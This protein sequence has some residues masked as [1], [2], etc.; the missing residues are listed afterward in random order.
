[1]WTQPCGRKKHGGVSAREL[2]FDSKL[3]G[4]RTS[5]LVPVALG[6][7]AP[8]LAAEVDV[9]LRV[10][11]AADRARVLLG[12]PVANAKAAEDMSA[13]RLVV[14]GLVVV[15][16]HRAHGH[17]QADAAGHGFGHLLLDV[18]QTRRHIAVGGEAAHDPVFRV[19]ILWQ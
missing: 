11:A 12:E 1:M 13:G 14:G 10:L 9:R 6:L 5:L 8:D 3:A 2:A 7:R 18:E 4:P 16:Q 15:E 19:H 17:V